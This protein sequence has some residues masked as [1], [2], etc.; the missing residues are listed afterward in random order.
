DSSGILR[1][2]VDAN[3]R[4]LFTLH[5]TGQLLTEVRDYPIAGNAGDL[6]PRSVIYGYD[7]YNRLTS[8]TDARGGITYYDYDPQNRLIKITDQEGR[9]EQ[10]DYIGNAIVKRTAPD[11]GVTDSLYSYDTVQQ[12]FISKI[13]GPE[14]AA[15]RKQEEFIH[16]R[17]GKLVQQITNGRTDDQV[18]YDPAA[19]A[20]SHTN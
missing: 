17:S 13:T 15:G 18:I 3:G 1:G 8:V 9:I 4:V 7:S 19:R 11:G 6:P 12:Q 5:Y 20:E 2:V 14:T 10:F 16:N